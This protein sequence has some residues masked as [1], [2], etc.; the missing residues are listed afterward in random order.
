M[1]VGTMNISFQIRIEKTKL[2]VRFKRRNSWRNSKI[3]LDVSG[4][5]NYE[6]FWLFGYDVCLQ[7]GYKLK[8]PK[9]A[10]PLLSEK[11]SDHR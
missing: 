3:R 5:P 11:K 6:R 4:F 9:P 2:P 10:K 8:L 7:W 1:G